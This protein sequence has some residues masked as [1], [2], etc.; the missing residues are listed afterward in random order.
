MPE[1][2]WM[3]VCTQLCYMYTLVHSASALHAR[4]KIDS[5][6]H[7]HQ[8]ICVSTDGVCQ[9]SLAFHEKSVFIYFYKA[10]P[11]KKLVVNGLPHF[12]SP[13]CAVL[14]CTAILSLG[15]SPTLY[16][17]L[18]PLRTFYLYLVTVFSFLVSFKTNSFESLRYLYCLM[19]SPR[20]Q[21]C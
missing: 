13:N 14:Y 19:V 8:H 2:L 5:A 10:L 6:F 9:V 1:L 12:V 21:I 11:R 16:A 18:C 4:T 20:T 7:G 17:L 3:G 15:V